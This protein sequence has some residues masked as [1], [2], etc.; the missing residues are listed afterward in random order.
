LT[1]GNKEIYSLLINSNISGL[2]STNQSKKSL[3]PMTGGHGNRNDRYN[4]YILLMKEINAT[5][6]GLNFKIFTGEDALAPP[7]C[8]S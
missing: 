1:N 4:L 7:P 8:P 5:S 3:K 2:S 6:E